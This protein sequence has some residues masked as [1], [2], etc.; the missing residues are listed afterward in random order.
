MLIEA[1]LLL[2]LGLAALLVFVATPGAIGVA[3]YFEFFDKPAGYKDHARPTPYLGGTA[4]MAGFLLVALILAGDLARSLPVLSGAVVLWVVGTVDDRRY[5]SPLLRA[6]I[7]L[8]LAAGVWAL[9]AGWDLGH[10]EMIDFAVTCLWI[11]G[12]VNAVNLF[13]NMDGASSTM[14]LVVSGAVAVLG[15]ITGDTWLVATAAALCGACLG[16]L[17]YNT[18]Q[19]NARIFLGDGGSMPIGFAVA[20]LVMIGSGDALPGLQGL[21]IGLLLIGILALDTTL[22]IVSRLRKGVS[23]LTGGRDHLTHRTRRRM[24]T[25]LAVATTLGGVQTLL[26]TVALLSVEADSNTRRLIAVVYFAAGGAIIAFL[27]AEEDRLCVAAAAPSEEAMPGE[28]VSR[29]AKLR[30]RFVRSDEPMVPPAASE[31][32]RR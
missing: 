25:A 5:V 26:A 2:G 29:A 16:F 27:E 30:A 32:G 23:I 28:V 11:L 1:R 14:A 17:P 7:E 15:L 31:A 22:V 6:A 10:G 13:D 21:L 19:P 9:G 8:A 3:G 12:V 20:T 18:A 4:V 24:D